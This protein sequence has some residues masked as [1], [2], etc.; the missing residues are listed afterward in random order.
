MREEED[1]EITR[2]EATSS[3]NKQ[4]KSTQATKASASNLAKETRGATTTDTS[5]AH[6]D[7]RSGKNKY[8]NGVSKSTDRVC[9]V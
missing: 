5:R 8:S 7:E 2:A 9:I 3:K 4:H 1:K 6:S